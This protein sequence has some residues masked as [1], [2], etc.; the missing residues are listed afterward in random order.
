MTI[1]DPGR[2]AD[3]GICI[4]Y[5][6]GYCLS[7][8]AGGIA[9]D[10]SLCNECGECAALCPASAFRLEGAEVRRIDRAALPSPESLL[11][12]LKSRR[13]IRHF[14]AEK[15][16]RATLE[17]VVAAGRYAPTMNR[18]IRAVVIDDPEILAEIDRSERRFYG[19]IYRLFFK[20][21]AFLAFMRLLSDDIDASRRKLERSL[22]GPDFLY[23]ASALIVLVGDSRT[24]LTEESAQ[25]CLASMLLYAQAL[26][27]GACLMDSAKLALRTSRA[28]RRRLGIPRGMRAR[29]AM[30]LGRPEEKIL[31]LV[32]GLSLTA[33]W[34]RY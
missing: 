2:C 4:A 20:N 27:L 14:T 21:R 12:L 17:R 31:N 6:G 22:G 29:G 16:D 18:G 23:G 13:S 10:E 9:V 15:V 28:L 11:E 25:Y 32:D 8:A 3:C 19:T 33:G 26:G 24:V 7:K 30:V 5:R 1:H 34:N